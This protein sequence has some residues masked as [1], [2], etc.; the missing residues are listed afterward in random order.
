M[1]QRHLSDWY[2]FSEILG[3]ILF[4]FYLPP[5]DHK[6][7]SRF[8][9]FV[10]LFSWQSRSARDPITLCSCTLLICFNH[11]DIPLCCF[12][13]SNA[14]ILGDSFLLSNAFI[15]VSFHS[16]NRQLLV[17]SWV[18][19]FNCFVHRTVLCVCVCVS[20]YTYI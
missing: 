17:I 16:F 1:I 20:V 5:L 19:G 8:C 14:R 11:I 4:P 13:S 6:M 10:H 18:D 7:H 15:E 2:F 12:Q 9:H 3:L